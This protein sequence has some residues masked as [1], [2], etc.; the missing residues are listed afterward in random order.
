M[1]AC[2]TGLAENSPPRTDFLSSGELSP[3][4]HLSASLNCVQDGAQ[5]PIDGMAAD[6]PARGDLRARLQQQCEGGARSLL[7]RP[8]GER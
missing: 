4:G 1:R 6:E 5:R 7:P 2:A 3:N 8:Q